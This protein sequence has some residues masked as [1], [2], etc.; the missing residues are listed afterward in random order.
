MR[1]STHTIV[2]GKGDSDGERAIGDARAGGDR[3]EG[4]AIARERERER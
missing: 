4:R 2:E 1:A 3:R